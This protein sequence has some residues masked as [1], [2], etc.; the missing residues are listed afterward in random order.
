MDVDF[1][2]KFDHYHAKA[3]EFGLKTVWSIYEVENLNDMHPFGKGL[4]VVYDANYHWGG[5][6]TIA[7][8]HGNTWLDLF[9]AADKC[10][11]DSGDNHH[12]YIESFEPSSATGVV[13]LH[14][15]S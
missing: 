14:T 5:K 4:E 2:R 9:I 10:V 12:I 6:T 1:D 15:G 3:K 11:R 7:A 8:V 13:Y